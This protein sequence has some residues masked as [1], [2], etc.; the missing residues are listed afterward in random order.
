MVEVER[1]PALAA[2]LEG[3]VDASVESDEASPRTK[4]EPVEN[5]A[6]IGPVGRQA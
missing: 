3:L 6:G 5:D 2:G 1:W 4:R